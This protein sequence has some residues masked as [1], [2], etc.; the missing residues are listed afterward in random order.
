ML[1]IEVKRGSRSRKRNKIQK[2]IEFKIKDTDIRRKR[3]KSHG[4][5][6]ATESWTEADTCNSYRARD[7][8]HAVCSQISLN[9]A[10]RIDADTWEYTLVNVLR[11][12]SSL[13]IKWLFSE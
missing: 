11:N 13:G 9:S 12:A 4:T 5:G 6:N 1:Y 2:A 8:R 7:D 10:T 3:K